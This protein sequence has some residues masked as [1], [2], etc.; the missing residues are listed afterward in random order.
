MPQACNTT[1]FPTPLANSFIL[2]SGVTDYVYNNR[3]RFYDYTK[4]GA[5]D[6]IAAGANIVKIEGWGTVTIT[7]DCDGTPTGQRT[8]DLYNTAHIPSFTS[9]L[10]SYN[11]F[12]DKHLFWDSENQC[13]KYQGTQ[14]G[15]T[16]RIYEQ[17][18]LEYNAVS[19]DLSAFLARRSDQ[20][21]P[22]AT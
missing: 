4:A 22:P 12:Y 17:W 8:F 7:M 15:K 1:A 19:S 14:V 16:K 5:D 6:Y 10:V 21:L 13:I 18:V 3:A 20:P 9:N 2:D 11:R